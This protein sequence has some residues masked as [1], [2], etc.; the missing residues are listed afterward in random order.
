MTLNRPLNPLSEKARQC[1][2][3]RKACQA[4]GIVT[5]PSCGPAVRD[6]L[7][8]LRSS[9]LLLL[10]KARDGYYHR[11]TPTSKPLIGMAIKAG[12]AR[13]VRDEKLYAITPAGETWLS[14]LE[15]HG[16]LKSEE[17]AA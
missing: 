10:D 2:R 4:A 14:E 11:A 3:F 8:S 13:F 12:F 5:P 7:V 6:I 1:E 9:P 17:A 15:I 16:L